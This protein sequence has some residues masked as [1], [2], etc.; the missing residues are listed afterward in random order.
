MELSILNEGIIGAT[1][2]RENESYSGL[3]YHMLK[4]KTG[5]MTVR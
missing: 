5:R 4:N 2:D 3:E 1:Q